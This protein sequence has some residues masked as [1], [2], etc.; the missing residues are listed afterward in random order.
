VKQLYRRHAQ[1][2]QY[3][4]IGGWNTVSGYGVFIAI[5]YGTAR[6]NLHYVVVLLLSQ[7]INVTSAYLLYKK[8]VFKTSG[9]YLQ[10][11]FRF[12]TFYWVSLLGNFMLLP[13]LVELLWFNPVVAQGFL[14]ITTAMISYF[15]HA[16]YTFGLRNA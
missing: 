10:E 9:N 3:L 6:F 15:W 13:L 14:T 7:I 4:L 11:Y 12:W 8:F 2:L 5:F 16:N 1:K